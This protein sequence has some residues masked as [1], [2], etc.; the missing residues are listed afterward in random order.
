MKE[1]PKSNKAR[2]FE[3]YEDDPKKSFA[4]DDSEVHA[5]ISAWYLND[6]FNLARDYGV[7][8]E[9]NDGKEKYC[10]KWLLMLPEKATKYKGDITLMI[11]AI[12][13]FWSAWRACKKYFEIT[14]KE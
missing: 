12:G 10:S 11:T 3:I 5:R 6:Q 7:T 2:Y 1:I 8:V 14:E 13:D 4:S 9:E